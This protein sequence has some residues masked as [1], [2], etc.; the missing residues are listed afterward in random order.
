MSQGPQAFDAVKNPNPAQGDNP[1]YI[2]A[3]L[4]AAFAAR[5]SLPRDNAAENAAAGFP[6]QPDIGYWTNTAIIGH[7]FTWG[8]YWWD[9]IQNATF[10]GAS[11]GGSGT[12]GAATGNPNGNL[13]TPQL[14]LLED[15]LAYRLAL[16]C[17]NVLQP[18]KDKYPNIVIV[19][20]FRQTNTGI[21]QHELGEAVDIQLRNQPQ[22]GRFATHEVA[23]WISKNLVFDQLILNLTTVGDG[24]PWIHVSFSGKSN[25]QQVLTKDFSDN[26]HEGLFDVQPLTGE[27]AAQV[28]RDQADSDAKILTELQN[29][30]TRQTRFGKTPPAVSAGANTT[31]GATASAGP[32]P[33]AR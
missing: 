26:F 12:G 10:G 28:L 23:D 17:V 30:Q 20:G 13:L 33:R 15:D 27:A 18:L 16:L 3:M 1:A 11:D 31:T 14:G 4:H 9:K 29:I 19:S 24:S 25:R 6:N 5:G 7:G 21:G 22:E 8:P 2:A 32:G